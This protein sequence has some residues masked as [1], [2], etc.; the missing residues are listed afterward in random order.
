MRRPL[1]KEQL[2]KL[3]EQTDMTAGEII[4][5]AV[6]KSGAKKLSD[7]MKIPDKEIMYRLEEEV[8]AIGDL[9]MTDEEFEKWIENK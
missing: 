4:Y 9:R 8:N 7:I 6:I 5:S 1:I 2:V 3:F